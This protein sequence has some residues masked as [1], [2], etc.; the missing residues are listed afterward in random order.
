M[1]SA[2]ALPA[3][4]LEPG[5]DPARRL[6]V[7]WPHAVTREWAWGDALG[8]GVRVCILDS[9]I[10]GGH[11][12][13]GGIEGAMTARDGER[14]TVDI[15]PDDDGG[16]VS[17]H[18]TACAGIV[19]ALAPR[20]RLTSVRVLGPALSG[21]GDH[22][23]AGL[24][25]AV[26]QRFDVVNLSLSMSSPRLVEALHEVADRA[27]FGG[28]TIVASAHNLPVKS[29]PWRFAAVLS[30]ASH[31]GRDPLEFH[32]NPDPPVELFARGVDVEVAWLGGTTIRATGNSFAAPHVAG[33]CAR[34]LGAHP[35]LSAS[36]LRAA[37]H[38]T[39]SNLA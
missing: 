22:L 28:T 35:G 24:R 37:L 18:G 31:A 36:E 33:L 15:V 20:A 34:V 9:G 6:P 3:W 32:V 38:L 5:P 29:Y 16:D 19:R 21:G 4:S 12:R 17:G 7:D 2:E 27:F 14:G 11:P 13:V 30:V 39:A 25:W 10:D 8:E 1:S 26:A 23:L